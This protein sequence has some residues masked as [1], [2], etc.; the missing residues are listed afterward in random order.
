[1]R[2]SDSLPVAIV[3][4]VADNGV[5]GRGNA[6]PWDLPD[7]L[8]HFKQTTMGRPIIMG[9]KTFESIGRPLPGRLNIILTRDGAWR[10]SGVSVATSMA[11]AMEIAEGQALIDGARARWQTTVGGLQDAMRVQAGVVGNLDTNRAQMSALIGESQGATGALQATQ[12]GNQLLALQSQQISDLTAL[13]A[14]Q[15]RA[16]NL[17]AAQ[18]AAAQEQAREQRRRVLEPG[19]GYQPGNAQMFQN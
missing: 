18:M 2:G 3:V 12:A 8:Q 14:A 11:Q 19:T 13:M 17:E 10:A 9:R 15:G 6:L 5:I 4:A 1:M 7:D 16:Q